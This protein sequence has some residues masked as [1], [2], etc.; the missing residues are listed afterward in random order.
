MYTQHELLARVALALAIPSVLVGH[1]QYMP[2]NGAEVI[3]VNDDVVFF[4]ESDLSPRGLGEDGE[5]RESEE[6][7][8]G[9]TE[10]DFLLLAFERLDLAGGVCVG[11]PRRAGRDVLLVGDEKTDGR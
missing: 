4:G 3:E 2:V 7:E 1:F 9:E 11:G 6:E 8:R 5:G 10:H